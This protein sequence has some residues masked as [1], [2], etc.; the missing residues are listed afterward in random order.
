MEKHKQKNYEKKE[1]IELLLALV[2][3]EKK[4][5]MY[6]FSSDSRIFGFS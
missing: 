6:I 2:F 1:F 4:F 3:Q 5:I